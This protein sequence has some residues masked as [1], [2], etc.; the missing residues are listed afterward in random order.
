[1]KQQVLA[2]RVNPTR[3]ALPSPTNLST[4]ALGGRTE[5]VLA[6]NFLKRGGQWLA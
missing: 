5:K 4:V 1:V 6:I 2:Y 3:S